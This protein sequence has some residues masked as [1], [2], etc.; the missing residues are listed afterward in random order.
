MSEQQ[1]SADRLEEYLDRVTGRMTLRVRTTE[2]IIRDMQA[3]I[4]NLTSRNRAL[5]NR[6]N[7]VTHDYINMEARY[8]TLE[9]QVAVVL[10]RTDTLC[11]LHAIDDEYDVLASQERK[12]PSR[13]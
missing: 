5:Q 3:Q 10:A 6:I 8:E 1:M 4:D 13:D 12:T 2:E 7:D 9:R 11:Q